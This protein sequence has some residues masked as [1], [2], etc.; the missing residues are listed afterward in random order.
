M[1]HLI[2]LLGTL[3]LGLL[4]LLE[5]NIIL[6]YTALRISIATR[7]P[8][9]NS[10]SRHIIVLVHKIVVILL[11]LTGAIV[12]VV[13]HSYLVV[14]IISVS[15]LLILVLFTPPLICYN[16]LLILNIRQTSIARL[17]GALSL[18]I[19]IIVEVIMQPCHRTTASIHILTSCLLLLSS[20]MVPKGCVG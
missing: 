2:R 12:A 11:L 18:L 19:Y 1:P 14:N 17:L 8:L 15:L 9:N 16:L 6:V 4:L 10:L 3:S 13:L 7:A 20:C 5:H